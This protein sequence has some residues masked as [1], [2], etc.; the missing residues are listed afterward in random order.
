MRKSFALKS[1]SEVF[2]ENLRLDTLGEGG[3]R[4]KLCEAI[5]IKNISD[6]NSMKAKSKVIILAVKILSLTW[7]FDFY[8]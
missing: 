8:P 3:R 4:K 1:F 7:T 5:F 6:Q 2:R